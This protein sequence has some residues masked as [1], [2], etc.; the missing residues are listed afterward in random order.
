MICFSFAC[1]EDIID[2]DN[3]P[4]DAAEDAFRLSGIFL[5]RK[6]LQKANS[7]IWRIPVVYVDYHVLLVKQ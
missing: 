2:V 7:W 6:G 1:D 4:R 5:G 3:Q